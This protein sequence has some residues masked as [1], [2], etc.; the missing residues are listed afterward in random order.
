MSEKQ[1]PGEVGP[2]ERW[3]T[4][5]RAGMIETFRAWADAQMKRHDDKTTILAQS[6]RDAAF[7]SAIA[8]YEVASEIE[9]GRFDAV[10]VVP[11]HPNRKG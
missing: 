7:H 10:K 5:N 2:P 1:S 11:L 3:Q 4:M 6:Q 9:D 8:L